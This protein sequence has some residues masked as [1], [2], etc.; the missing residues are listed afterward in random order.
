MQRSLGARPIRVAALQFK[1]ML[2]MRVAVKDIR[3]WFG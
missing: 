3:A 2:D 1:L